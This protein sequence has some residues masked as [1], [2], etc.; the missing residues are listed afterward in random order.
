M[1]DLEGVEPH[2]EELPGFD[3]DLTDMRT[4]DEFPSRARDYVEAIERL[5]GVPV[6]TISVGPGR[7]Q[8]VRR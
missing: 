2:F 6:R 1:F 5:A 8:V 3:E 7:E 4:Y